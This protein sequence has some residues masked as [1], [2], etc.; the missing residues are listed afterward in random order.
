MEGPKKAAPAPSP[1]TGSQPSLATA[2]ASHGQHWLGRGRARPS[3]EDIVT[4]QFQ[5]RRNANGEDGAATTVLG[6]VKFPMEPTCGGVQAALASSMV[7]KTPG[8][9]LIPRDCM[10][11]RLPRRLPQL[12][13]ARDFLAAIALCGFDR[14]LF[15]PWVNSRRLAMRLSDGISLM[16]SISRSARRPWNRGHAMR[17][18]M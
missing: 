3:L 6:A 9:Y 4:F 12:R 1:A 18:P 10:I 7:A 15:W 11:L 17:W 13:N 2:L 5:N 14:V 8:W 16:W